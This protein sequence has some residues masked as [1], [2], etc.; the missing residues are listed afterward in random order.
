MKQ[1]VVGIDEVGR[2]CL[3]GPVTVAAV[4]TTANAKYEIQN[5]KLKKTIR[6]IKD[7]KKLSPKQRE[8]W[9]EKFKLIQS[10]SLSRPTAQLQFVIASVGPA[11]I[12]RVGISRAARIAV[13]RCLGKLDMKNKKVKILLD[14][15]LYAPRTYQNQKTIIKGD[16]KI[17][18]IAAASI[19]AKVT[20]DRA[21][22]RLHERYQAYGFDVHKGYG[23]VRHQ[24]AIKEV[25]MSVIHRKSFCTKIS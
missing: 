18:L 10:T 22:V 23:T 9:L 1:Y 4:A 12:D 13:S 3:A 17:P 24:N 15:S 19:V 2:G 16:E 25:G 5:T 21:M 7:S 14:G 8:S 11:I 6:H 20:R